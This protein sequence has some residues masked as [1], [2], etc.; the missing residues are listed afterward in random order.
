MDSNIEG[1]R[2]PYHCWLKRRIW[3]LIFIGGECNV[4][5]LIK[6]GEFFNK[7]GGNAVNTVY[8]EI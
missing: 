5:L 6:Y 8:Y 2:E 1:G 3:T 4:L 7:R